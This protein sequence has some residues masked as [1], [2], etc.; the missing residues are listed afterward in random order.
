MRSCNSRSAEKNI[1]R[2]IPREVHQ[3][4]QRT[5]RRPSILPEDFKPPA[6]LRWQNEQLL[7]EQQPFLRLPISNSLFKGYQR[8]IMLY[9]ISSTNLNIPPTPCP[10]LFLLIKSSTENFFILLWKLLYSIILHWKPFYF[11]IHLS[12]CKICIKNKFHVKPSYCH[13]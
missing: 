12:P 6:S 5:I 13:T 4:F 8:I 2:E 7:F 1:S 11:N 10:K 3:T 9:I